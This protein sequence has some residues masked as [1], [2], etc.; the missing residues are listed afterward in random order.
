MK[1]ITILCAPTVYKHCS[2]N[3]ICIMCYFNSFE[4]NIIIPVLQIDNVSLREGQCFSKV[5]LLSSSR[6]KMKVLTE[7][8]KEEEV[9][10]IWKQ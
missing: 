2:N 8:G 4:I 1:I 6:T 3:F 5:T 10:G 7:E 9:S